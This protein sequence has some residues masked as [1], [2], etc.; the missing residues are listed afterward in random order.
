WVIEVAERL[1][2]EGAVDVILEVPKLE[3]AFAPTPELDWQ[4]EVERDLFT[5]LL[6][7]DERALQ[8]AKGELGSWLEL[9]VAARVRIPIGTKLAAVRRVACRA[10][11]SEGPI[12]FDRAQIAIAPELPAMPTVELQRLR[13]TFGVCQRLLPRVRSRVTFGVTRGG[14]FTRVMTR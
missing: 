2:L 7:L 5:L 6:N 3:V 11:A 1:L 10:V 14:R 13:R 8:V 12:N 4:F 9:V